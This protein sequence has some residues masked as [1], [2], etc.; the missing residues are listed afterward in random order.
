MKKIIWLLILVPALVFA[1]P[2]QSFEQGKD[3]TV[4]TTTKPVITVPSNKISV[5]EFFSYAC[6]HCAN[7]EPTIDHWLKTKPANTDFTRVP[8]VFRPSWVVFAKAYY[9]AHA[10]GIDGKITP[11][12]FAAIHQK[13][14]NLASPEAMEKF[15]VAQGV[16]K[17]DF[18]SAFNYSPA[19]DAKL[20]Q[21]D[22]L[23]RDMRI[24]QVPTIVVAGRYVTTAGM[25][26]GN[27]QRMMDIVNF[28]IQKAQSERGQ[29]KS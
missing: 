18:D 17:K 29:N 19:I 3:F 4:L 7:L 25:A 1:A 5:V 2:K 21:G 8:V 26:K 28:L 15:F 11:Q 20:G 12:L 9:T 27:N 6:P 24:S 16:S 14:E 23:A 22:Q 10:L 13:N